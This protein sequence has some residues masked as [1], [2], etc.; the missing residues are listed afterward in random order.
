GRSAGPATD[1]IRAGDKPQGGE[2]AWSRNTFVT[3]AA[4][5]RDHRI[6]ALFAAPQESA[7]GPNRKF[8]AARHHACYGRRT[9]LSSDMAGTAAL[10]P[11]ETSG[12]GKDSQSLSRARDPSHT[13]CK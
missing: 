10:D 4:R 5:R 3:A 9:G 11:H 7:I 8:A 13:Q 6:T 2:G 1:Q 12:P